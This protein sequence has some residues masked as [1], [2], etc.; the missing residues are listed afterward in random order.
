MGWGFTTARQPV[1]QEHEMRFIF[2]VAGIA[3]FTG[4]VSTQSTVYTTQGDFMNQVAPGHYLEDFASVPNGLITGPL[5]YSGN[6]FAY[7]IGDVGTGSPGLWGDGGRLSTNAA[8]N[9]IVLTFTSGNVTAV[10]GNFWATD[11]DFNPIS[12]D[13]HIVLSDNTTVV[14]SASGP[15]EFR[16]FTSPMPLTSLSVSVPF[17]A[18]WPTLDNIVTGTAEAGC[19]PDCNS[20]QM[21]T[22]DDF[23]CFLNA[24]A[25][26]D[27]Y[28][29]CNG[30]G[31]L[32]VDD[33][34]CFR[35]EFA[36]G[37]P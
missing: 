16:G 2:A 24:F 12:A 8:A 7:S 18:G 26:Q 22:V 1:D 6:G 3:A 33:F 4:A 29:D 10:G 36:V 25:G 28:A 30:D 20:D 31:F 11:I 14:F 5:N 19:Y 34:I 37:C 27:P 21:L 17:S 35:N 23:I 9:A 13:V 32:T 15:N